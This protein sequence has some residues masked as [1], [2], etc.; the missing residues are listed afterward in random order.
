MRRIILLRHAE[1][2]ANIG[3]LVLDKSII[4]LTDEGKQSAESFSLSVPSLD[5]IIVSKY[6]RTI[7]TAEHL[8][9][10]F[11]NVDVSLWYDLNEFDYINP[12]NLLNLNLEERNN[13]ENEYWL[14]SNPFIKNHNNRENFKEFVDRVFGVIKKLRK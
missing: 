11:N 10:R 6:I 8:Y 4:K 5:R 12:T 7:E 3:E 9:K 1:S 14:N 2:I 13:V